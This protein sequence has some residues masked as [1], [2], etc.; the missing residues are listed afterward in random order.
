MKRIAVFGATGETGKLVVQQAL[1]IGYHVVAYVRNPSK[2]EISNE[3]LSIVR[4]ELSDPNLIERVV[5]DAVAVLSLL[6][7]RGGSKNKPLTAGMQNIIV[8][9]K[10][11][12][13][14][15]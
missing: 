14:S 1:D 6:G 10:K 12:V 4:G 8:A 11:R 9:M 3:H 5:T 15:G 13:C 7:P 2:L